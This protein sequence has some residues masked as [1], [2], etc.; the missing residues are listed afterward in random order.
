MKKGYGG[1]Q[2]KHKRKH[3]R[4]QLI[5]WMLTLEFRKKQILCQT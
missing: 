2:V 3:P 5:L 4:N 1:Q